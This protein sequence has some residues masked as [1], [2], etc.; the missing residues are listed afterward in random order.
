MKS[1]KAFQSIPSEYKCQCCGE[2]KPLNKEHFQIVNKFKYGYSTYCN[3]C[4]IVCNQ[5]KE[6]TKL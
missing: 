4:N 5:P 1:V 6:K 3:I 2:I